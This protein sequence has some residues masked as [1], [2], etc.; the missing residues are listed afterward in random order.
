M[1]SGAHKADPAILAELADAERIDRA[2]AEFVRAHTGQAIGG[3][4]PV[5]HP[6]RITTLVDTYLTNR[7]QASSRVFRVYRPTPPHYHATCDEYLLVVAGI[8]VVVGVVGGVVVPPEPPPPLASG[9]PMP[10]SGTTP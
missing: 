3:V 8:G 5:G 7:E 6:A 1:T 9:L 4:A 2:D 10:Q